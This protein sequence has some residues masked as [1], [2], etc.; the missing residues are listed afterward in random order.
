VSLLFIGQPGGRSDNE[1]DRLRAPARRAAPQAVGR[2]EHNH[3]KSN[4]ICTLREI[5]ISSRKSS[6]STENAVLDL[7]AEPT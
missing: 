2:R 1:T 5:S 4:G 6:T 3:E 7:A